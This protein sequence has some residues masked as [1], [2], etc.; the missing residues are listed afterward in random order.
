M[1][2]ITITAQQLCDAAKTA[3]ENGPTFSQTALKAACDKAC[4]GL[5]PCELPQSAAT[6]ESGF[7]Q[8]RN[9]QLPVASNKTF[10]HT[11]KILRQ[12]KL[13]NIEL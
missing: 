6:T 1:E 9:H 12:S 11:K 7:Y 4:E 2:D 8:D 10:P 5:D 13:F 3:L